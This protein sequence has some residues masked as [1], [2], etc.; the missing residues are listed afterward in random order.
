MIATALSKPSVKAIFLNK[1]SVLEEIFDGSNSLKTEFT[2]LS[3][4]LD[5]CF[6]VYN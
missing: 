1:V 2:K 3:I 5:S 6:I 4:N